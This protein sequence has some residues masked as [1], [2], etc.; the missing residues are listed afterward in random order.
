MHFPYFL[1]NFATISNLFFYIPHAMYRIILFL[2]EYKYS[3]KSIIYKIII[4]PKV[5]PKKILSNKINP[6]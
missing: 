2:P 4:L 6:T 5:T 1:I 3:K